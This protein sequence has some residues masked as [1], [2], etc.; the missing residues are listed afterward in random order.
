M[1]DILN[2]QVKDETLKNIISNN[3]YY[4][5]IKG[6][7]NICSFFNSRKEYSKIMVNAIYFCELIP[8]TFENNSENLLF[9]RIGTLP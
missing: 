1:A 3:P 6:S 9:L 5:D 4:I 2:L 8:N 7:V